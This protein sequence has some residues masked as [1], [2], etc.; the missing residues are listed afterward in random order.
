MA[1][2]LHGF[3]VS[4]A[5]ITLE[6]AGGASIIVPRDPCRLSTYVLLEQEDWFE[7]EIAFIR[8]VATAGGRMLDIGAN[9]GLYGLSYA[10]AAGPESR[11]WGFEPTPLVAELARRSAVASAHQ[12]VE[13]IE[14]ALG[15]RRG[16]ARLD[17]GGE[18]ELNRLTEN[19]VG[20]DVATARLDDVVSEH[21]IADVDCVKIDVEGA[22]ADVIAGGVAFF[23]RE[24]PL[25][26]L[27]VK[28][29]G[30]GCDFRAL[31]RL[32]TL[33]YA[34]YRL[35]PELGLLAP[36]DRG[37]V[38]GFLL[39]LFACKPDRAAQLV[40]RGLLVAD[41][42]AP[43]ARITRAEL[44]MRLV[45]MPSFA[46]HADSVASLVARAQAGDPALDMLVAYLAAA[47]A[48]R[49]AAIRLAS[50]R[51]AA[52]RARDEAATAQSAVR[53]M[54][55]SRI[56]RGWGDRGIAAAS[57]R[58]LVP[59]L[60]AQTQLR[61]D[62]PFLPPLAA[63]DSW[64]S[65]HGL[66]A[67]LNASIIEGIGSFARF[68]SYFHEPFPEAIADLLRPF[69]RAT[70]PLERQRQLRRIVDGAQAAL[71]PHALLRDHRPDNLN[72]NIWCGTR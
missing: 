31:D 55:A 4:D 62:A 47:D 8:R 49:P 25:V 70:A 69:G 13:L 64:S 29:G 5:T 10:R 54:T 39:N 7:D 57:L 9:L 21:A 38:D 43:A 67:W 20:I 16:R 26:M 32:G 41:I 53:L 35:V 34:P 52:A 40:A 1:P 63:Y 14:T 65:E 61:I 30:E 24:S 60:L 48:N 59:A 50:L 58:R 17:T 12:G 19:G 36:F 72:P 68:S 46:A 23:A 2:Q 28:A 45:A 22:E 27:E 11:V 51:I 15:A 66:G 42:D 56:L 44:E 33:G 3:A 18:S 6:I 71:E 37:S